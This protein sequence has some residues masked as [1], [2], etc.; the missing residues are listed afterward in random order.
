MQDRITE[1]GGDKSLL[2]T[3]EKEL[4][5]ISVEGKFPTYA[6]LDRVRKRVGEGFRGKGPYK[7]D[8]GGILRQV[9]KVLSEDQQGVSDAF[10]VGANYAAARRLV[11]S[12]KQIED[13]SIALLGKNL[14]GSII[15]KITQAATAL[16]KGD[17]SKFR[18]LMETLPK[19]RRA[20]VAAT[21]LNDIF[22][23]GARTKGSLGQGFVKAFAGLSRNPAAKKILFEQLPK[24]AEARFNKLGIV[25]TGLFRSKAFENTS[26]TARALLANMEDGSL[27]SK[28]G[29]VATKAAVI[30]P[31]TAAA[32]AP[33][34]GIAAAIITT[35]AKRTTPAVEAADAFI[36]SPKFSEAIKKA[37]REDIAGAEAVVKRDPAFQ[38]W[39]NTLNKN[40]ASKI[41][42]VGF[43]AW[44]LNGDRTGQ[45]NSGLLNVPQ[46][47]QFG[48]LGRGEVQP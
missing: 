7:D 2:T 20:E 21:L 16:T 1:L 30:E 47:P 17:V 45:R 12:R 35:I 44:L 43:I 19:G 13:Q 5:R 38:R 31:F 18:L 46:Q 34:A 3:A 11:Q 25:A 28:I 26:G 15:P 22:T 24:G 40:D 32:G 39:L 6:A 8:D 10:G 41:G 37:A 36:T 23:Q 29:G 48:L 14:S 33:G 9:Y 42:Q 27:F 4:L